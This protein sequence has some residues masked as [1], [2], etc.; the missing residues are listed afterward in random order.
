[1]WH[2]NKQCYDSVNKKNLK[3][4]I[5]NKLELRMLNWFRVLNNAS[6]H[7]SKELMKYMKE[8]RI[9]IAY[10][11]SYSPKLAPIEKYFE[12]LKQIVIKSNTGK[13]IKRKCKRKKD[14]MES[15]MTQISHEKHMKFLE[16]IYSWN[17]QKIVWINRL[18][19][20][21]YNI[22]LIRLILVQ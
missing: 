15:S 20:N 21:N 10:I 2:C 16:D 6:I 7:C 18:K 17:Q 12:L 11:P 19:F 14:D 5:W 13:Q 3:I 9:N 8:E 1:M 4:F 22:I